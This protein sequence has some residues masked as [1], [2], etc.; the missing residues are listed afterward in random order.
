MPKSYWEKRQELTY[1][2]GEKKVSAYYRGLQ[3]A[4]KQAK[5]EIQSVINDFYM[6]YAKEN[7]VSYAE[8]QKLLN[9]A[10]IGELQ[11]FIDLV[12]KNMGKYNLKLVN[13]SIKAR[14]TRYQALE[15]QIDAILQRLYALEYEYKGKELLKEVYTD[16]YYRTWFNID[17]YHGFHQEFA[18]INP[19]TIDELIRYPFNGADFSSRI[20]K[21]KDH[22][23]QALTEDITT[24]LV[25][26]KNPQTLARDFAKRFKTKEYE[27]YRLLHTESSFVIEQG[28]LAA[29]KED[30]VEKYQILATLDHKT[31]EICREQDGEIY[32]TDKA[33]VGVN[34]PPFHPFC[35]TTTVPYYEEDEAGTRAARDP[36]TGKTYYVPSNMKYKDWKKTFVDG[37]PKDGLNVKK[38]TKTLKEQIQEIKDK[39]EQKGGIIKES[40]IKEAGK[41]I[42]N[43]LQIKRADLK[44]EIEKLEKEYKATGIEEIENQLSKLR[45]A[46]RGLI[47]LDEVGLKDM[48]ELNIKYNELMRNKIELHSKTAELENKL[49]LAREK[50]KGTLK[51][52]AEELKKKLSEIREVG[53]SSFDIDGHLNKSRSPM[54]KVVKEAYDYYPTDWVE[55][56]I[57]RGNLKPKKV[58]RGYYSDL[59]AEIAISGWNEE[60]YF[61]TA[62]HELGHRF[63]RAVPGILEAEKIFY[64]RRTA[65][66]ALR[67][68]GGNYRYDEKSRFD[69]FLNPYMGK[70]YGGRAYELV[71]MGFE[72]AYTNPTKLWEDEDFATWIYGI[73]A[74]Y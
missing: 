60:G 62:L 10:E 71:S 43:E 12:N 5:R 39:I 47:D 7:K 67:W 32:E 40:D 6:R 70:D 24:M 44:A 64:E 2:A 11:D 34:Y 3:K 17:Q 18:Q 48:D 69:K 28:S 56:S 54:R 29:Y 15:K 37:G 52:N 55:K 35:R 26:G 61:M 1:L 4:F 63:E 49:K 21:Q 41:L 25:Q 45:A 30:G 8:A 72:Y 31:S 68:L 50:Y 59:H 66:E 46:R 20:W 73:L 22:M 53:I 14:I 58:D 9:K 16:A 27:A 65:G 33:T 36:K 42:Q 23:L 57:A 74:L 19:R 38:I 13:M 51:E